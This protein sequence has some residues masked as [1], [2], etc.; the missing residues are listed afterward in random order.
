LSSLARFAYYL[1]DF[2]IGQWIVYFKY[3]LRGKVVL[4]DR[5]YFDFIVDG[6]RSNIHLPSA[7]TQS[8]L[9]FISKPDFN[10]YLYASP[11][12][13]RARKQELEVHTISE[14]DAHYKSLFG[15]LHTQQPERFQIVENDKLEHTL[16]TIL[17]Q[18]RTKL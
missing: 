17:K 13:I 15:N 10:A 9:P 4:F 14:L 3:T 1:T 12:M 8:F 16:S 11:E 18:I 6:R 5:Y 7:F 2:L